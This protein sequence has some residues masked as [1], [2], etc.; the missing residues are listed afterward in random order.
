MSFAGPLLA[1]LDPQP[2]AERTCGFL[3]ARLVRITL[4]DATK[5]RLG[6]LLLEYMLQHSRRMAGLNGP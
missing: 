3:L 5:L 1:F 2:R 6:E 4:R